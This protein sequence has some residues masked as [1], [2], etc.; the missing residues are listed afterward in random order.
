MFTRQPFTRDS[1][2]SRQANRRAA[3]VVELAL[4]LPVIMVL[5]VASIECCDMIHVQQALQVSA[6]EG[7]RKAAL[8]DS[9][10]AEVLQVANNLLAAYSITGATT[11]ISPSQI[12]N[13]PKGTQITLTVSAALDL[14][15]K[16]VDFMFGGRTMTAT[17]VMVKE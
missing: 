2:R 15:R 7:A 10:S 17:C 8:P 14:N 5:V 3:A 4:C 9:D 12:S 1:R 16:S 13:V 11:K 6:Y